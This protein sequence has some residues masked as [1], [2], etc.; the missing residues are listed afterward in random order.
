MEKPCWTDAN[1][2]SSIAAF[3]V[4]HISG[5][6]VTMTAFKR[7]SDLAAIVGT[8]TIFLWLGVQ[9]LMG[10]QS[11]EIPDF[12]VNYTVKYKNIKVGNSIKS[13]RKKGSETLVIEHRF[14]V[15]SLLR[16]LGQSPHSQISKIRIDSDSRLSPIEYT[17]IDHKDN[18]LPVKAKFDWTG[19]R[20]V[21]DNGTIWP[22]PVDDVQDWETWY[23]SFLYHPI[24]EKAGQ[25]IGITEVD[26]MD[27]YEYGQPESEVL[28]TTIGQVQTVRIKMLKENRK[29]QG[30]VVWVAPAFHNLPVKIQRFKKKRVYNLDLLTVDWRN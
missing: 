29:E 28:N 23:A 2:S 27:I 12:D 24:E 16:L 21:V 5:N 19:Q 3:G 11:F 6:R 20:I 1:R 22:F 14:E 26:D 8:L 15:G 18:A 10:A 4:L 30:F 9:N 17:F 25:R 13:F 7:I